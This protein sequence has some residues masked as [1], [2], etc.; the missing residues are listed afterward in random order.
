MF[1]VGALV[2]M[3]SVIDGV[4]MRDLPFPEASRLVRFSTQ[5][6]SEGLLRSD[7]YGD[8]QDWRARLRS[9][10]AIAGYWEGGLSRTIERPTGLE[11]LP[12]AMVTQD[13]AQ[14]LGI[15]PLLG[16]HFT[17]ADHVP[18]AAPVVMLTYDMWQRDFN[19]ARDVVGRSL[20]I[21]DTVRTIVGVLPRLEFAYPP[22]DNA[23]WLPAA[24]VGG[25]ATR[26]NTWLAVT[27]RLKSGVSLEQARVEARAVSAQLATEL[28]STNKD[29]VLRLEALRD[30]MTQP[31]RSVLMLLGA[32]VACLLVIGCA[33]IATVLFA[34]IHERA[35]ELAV[36]SAIGGSA[37][38][39]TWQLAVECLVLTG[40][41]GI[42]GAVLS[43]VARQ[44]LLSAYPGA[45][46]RAAEVAVSARVLLLA[47]VAIVGAALAALLPFAWSL[48]R[49]DVVRELRSGRGAGMSREH[50]R[51]GATLVIGQVSVSLALVF[52]AA[53]LLRTAWRV[54]HIDP[55]FD[56]SGVLSFNFSV[57]AGYD[58]AAQRDALLQQILARAN[59]IPTVRQAEAVN[60]LPM[61]NRLIGYGTSFSRRD[62]SDTARMPAQ[63]RVV[64]P[65]YLSMLKI[66]LIRGRWTRVTDARTDAYV[67]LINQALARKAF[68]TMDPIGRRI[69]TQGAE[70][71]I[72]GVVGDFHHWGLW[73]PPEPEL[74]IPYQQFS[75]SFMAVALRVTGDPTDVVAAMRAALVDIDRRIPRPTFS[76]LEDKIAAIKAPDHFRAI[77]VGTLASLALLLSAVGIYG[78]IASGVAAQTREIGIRMALGRESS[79]VRRDVVSRALRLVALGLLVG[80]LGALWAGRA[81]NAFVHGLPAYDPVSA[82]VAM[83]SFALAALVAVWWPARAASRVSPLDAMRE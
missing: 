54:S 67:V 39:V 68:G 78:V 3:F 76:L 33:N 64:T 20:R 49:L 7:N 37:T 74:Y 70:R 35:R 29:K 60:Y 6:R 15:T 65:S 44:A 32:A 27:G 57:P 66:P 82:V 63:L 61:P 23:V 1:C 16:R 56:A 47:F 28:P 71:E 52:A 55:G 41:G 30:E 69:Y 43:P 83:A 10:S 9:F 24:P 46:P 22:G 34:S 11:R 38:R 62:G 58:S 4:L 19:G 17:P 31:V 48:R 5:E 50:R 51:F 14:V 72:V 81:L 77:L 8:L 36:R 80:T 26:N 79:D 75:W 59:A 42:L 18:G 12:A 2:A 40:T 53:L 73:R 45:L 25:F 21:S 13:F